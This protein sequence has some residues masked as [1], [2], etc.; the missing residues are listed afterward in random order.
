VVAHVLG[1]PEHRVRIET[2]R[3][4]G[5]FG[6]YLMPGIEGHLALLVYRTGRPVRLV[7]DRAEILARSPKRLLS[8]MTGNQV[9]AVDHMFATHACDLA[10]HPRTGE[11]RILRYI[12][13][14][15]VGRAHDPEIIRGQILGAVAMGVGQAIW[16]SIRMPG[17]RVDVTGLHEYRICTSLDAPVGVEVILLESGAGVGPG[18]AK[19][20]GEVGAVAAP[21]AVAHA[22]YDAL[23]IQP[24]FIT[25]TPEELAELAESGDRREKT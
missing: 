17:G 1:L 15:D 6:K 9:G 4:G 18:G 7:L 11:V 2:P 8:P 12:A 20:V 16:E 24:T 22:L 25:L 5:S 10:V 19:G 14:Q 3:M 21:I 13:C 23:G